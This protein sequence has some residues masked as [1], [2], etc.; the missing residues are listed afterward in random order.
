ML[1]NSTN[2]VPFLIFVQIG[3]YYGDPNKLINCLDCLNMN[4][5]KTYSKTK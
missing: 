2:L 3:Y 4:N 1:V 5:I